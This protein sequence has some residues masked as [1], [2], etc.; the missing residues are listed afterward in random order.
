MFYFEIYV[1]ICVDY[2]KLLNL[3]WAL[4]IYKE[5]VCI[6]LLLCIEENLEFFFLF[7]IIR[8]RYRLLVIYVNRD[9]IWGG[10]VY[11]Y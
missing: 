1:F 3:V 11:R 4:Y 5:F 2:F 9:M 8:L 10:F 6:I 7:L